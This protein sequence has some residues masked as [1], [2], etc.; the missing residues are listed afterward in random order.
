MQPANR[1]VV[2]MDDGAIWSP[3]K[4]VT[5]TVHP[6]PHVVEFVCYDG[7]LGTVDAK[8][9]AVHKGE[10]ATRNKVA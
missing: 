7:V 4:E 3:Y 9:T 6:L 10:R 5:H 8:V 1:T 2:G